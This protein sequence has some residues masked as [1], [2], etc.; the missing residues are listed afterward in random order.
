CYVAENLPALLF[1]WYFREHLLRKD[2]IIE[3]LVTHI[4]GRRDSIEVVDERRSFTL[5]DLPLN[6]SDYK[7]SRVGEKAREF[8]ALLIGDDEIQKAAVDLMNYYLDAAIAQMLHLDREDLERL[9][10]DVRETLAEQD[11]E[12]ILLI[13]DF[14]KLQGI[15]RQVLAAVIERP[16]EPGRPRQ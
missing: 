13:E 4:I 2:Q 12:L 5:N 10:R 14:A 1:D 9:M 15:D 3:S 16:E 8:Y 11:V 7:P 6:M